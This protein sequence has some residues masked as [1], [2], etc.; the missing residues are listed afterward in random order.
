MIPIKEIAVKYGRP[1]AIV[2]QC[3]RVYFKTASMEEL[4]ELIGD[5]EVDWNKVASTAHIHWIKPVVFRVLLDGA[6]I[7]ADFKDK[8]K[9][10]L[11]L[12]TIKAL[13]T[14]KE[15]ERL[16]LL[17]REAGV[18]AIPYKGVAFSKQFYGDIA[19]RESSDIDLIIDPI[20]LPKAISVLNKEGLANPYHS[21]YERIG[22]NDYIKNYKD[23]T[24][25]GETELKE[26]LHLE[27]HWKMLGNYLALPNEELY[28]KLNNLEKSTIAST[29]I[30]LLSKEEHARATLLHHIFQDRIGYLKTIVD[31]G[32][33]LKQLSDIDAVLKNKAVYEIETDYCFNV[34]EDIIGIFIKEGNKKYNRKLN[35]IILNSEY[36]KSSNNKIPII[37]SVVY[38]FKS[39]SVTSSFYKNHL[40]GSIYILN[41][42]SS[43]IKPS[44]L[45]VQLIQ[46]P[47]YLYFLYFII[48]P[49]RLIIKPYRKL[50]K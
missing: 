29:T 8:F 3:C 7:P 37:S 12:T 26:R 38:Y 9:R 19:M 22:H 35:D 30:D 50:N 39:L 16:I 34:I 42:I 43:F 10:E 6:T 14:A 31:I 47:K 33:S 48:R 17:L 36:E 4:N 45:E 1:M 24:L 49:F 46:L 41:S 21:E 25:D 44:S 23:Y 40:K 5:A 28:F 15:T 18:R 2:V 27:L 32:I 11:Q 13:N 20:D